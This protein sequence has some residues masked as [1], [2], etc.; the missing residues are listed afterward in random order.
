MEKL[1]KAFFRWFFA[2][3]GSFSFFAI[4][5]YGFRLYGY[6]PFLGLLGYA[7]MIFL[8]L[9]ALSQSSRRKHYLLVSASLML[10]G[11][12]ASFDLI[13]SKEELIG[14]WRDWLDADISDPLANG[15][16]QSLTILLGIFCGSLASASLFYGLNIKNF[17][18]EKDDMGG[19]AS[20][21]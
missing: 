3:W 13:S 20:G 6:A 18:A 10:F 17:P 4:L 16:V 8:L 7:T 2:S 19:V 14:L 5:V 9:C 11:A 12:M 15:L 1:N 21:E